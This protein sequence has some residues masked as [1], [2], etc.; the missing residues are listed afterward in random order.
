MISNNSAPH[1]GGVFLG[2]SIVPQID[3]CTIAG[4]TATD[5]GGGVVFQNLLESDNVILTETNCW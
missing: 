1:A 3:N 5:Y 2:Y 4:N